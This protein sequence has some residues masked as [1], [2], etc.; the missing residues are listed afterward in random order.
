MASVSAPVRDSSGAVVKE[1][2]AMAGMDDHLVPWE[3]EPIDVS[4]LAPGR[5]TFVAMTSDPSGGAEGFGPYTDTLTI[6]VE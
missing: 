2:F 4:A 6:I 1:G 5:Y 3:T